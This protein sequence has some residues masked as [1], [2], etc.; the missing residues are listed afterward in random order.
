MRNRVLRSI[1]QLI[2]VLL[3]L[4]VIISLS[5]SMP[6][7]DAVEESDNDEMEN[8]DTS[9]EEEE[10]D[11]GLLFQGDI[12]ML[13]LVLILTAKFLSRNSQKTVFKFCSIPE[14]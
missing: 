11:E 3:F 1:L 9:M 14:A 5:A 6:F 8:E 7:E 12:C 2:R 13:S 4:A 10:S